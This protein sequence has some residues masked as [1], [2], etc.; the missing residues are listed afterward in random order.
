MKDIIKKTNDKCTIKPTTIN[1]QIANKIGYVNTK[2]NNIRQNIYNQKNI[3]KDPISINDI[4]RKDSNFINEKGE[5][6]L[7]Y[8]DL[9]MTTINAVKIAFENK[10]ELFLDATFKTVNKLYNQ[11]FIIRIYS[12]KFNEFF[13]I[14]FI[15]MTQKTKLLYKRDMNNFLSFFKEKNYIIGNKLTF[16]YSHGDIEEALIKAIKEIITD[17]K[18]KLCY[19]HFSQ[20]IMRRMHNTIYEDL[21]QRIPVSKTLILSCE[22]LSFIKPE[23]VFDVFYRLK[24]DVEDINDSILNDFYNF[25]KILYFKL[26]YG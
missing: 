1:S 18:I 6:I 2:Y 24:E 15:F 12:E 21:F 9:V 16:K 8:K 11:L 19:F 5:N 13:A 14:C 26:W 22:A 4:N 3:P 20:S 23:F 25:E 17:T 10:K 7:I